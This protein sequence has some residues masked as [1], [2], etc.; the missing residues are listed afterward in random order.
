MS[1]RP[2]AEAAAEAEARA[3][4]AGKDLAHCCFRTA[5]ECTV[6]P[7]PRCAGSLFRGYS[8]EPSTPVKCQRCGCMVPYVSTEFYPHASP[9][10]QPVADQRT[11]RNGDECARRFKACYP[12]AASVFPD[13]E[14]EAD[15]EDPDYGF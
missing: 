15:I 6:N 13:A 10:G 3:K 5:D 9:V 4:A 7:G 11:C 14:P 8:P 12:R 2:G 1:G